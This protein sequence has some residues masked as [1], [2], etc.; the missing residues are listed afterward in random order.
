[1][2][3]VAETLIDQKVVVEDEI[4]KLYDV[5]CMDMFVL[6]LT[7]GLGLVRI[8]SLVNLPFPMFLFFVA[9]AVNVV[10]FVH[11][12]SFLTSD[13]IASGSYSS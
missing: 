4:W 1:M 8:E 5:F 9:L 7:V 6:L 11:L 10:P 3:L 2:L 12:L 13:S